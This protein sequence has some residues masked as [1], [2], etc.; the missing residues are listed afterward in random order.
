MQDLQ[1]NLTSEFQNIINARPQG[2]VLALCLHPALDVTIRTDHGREISR[3]ENLGGKAVNVA[4]MLHLLGA[5]V[6]LLA[7]D[8]CAGETSALLEN[9]GFDCEL[10]PTNLSLRRNYKYIDADGKTCEQNGS[11][12]TLSP[13]HS[14]QLIDRVLHICRTRQISHLALCGSFPQGVEKGVYKYLTEQA[15]ALNISCVTDASGES[16]SLAVQ[17]KPR[18]IKPNFDEFCAL[19][20]QDFSL[21][22]TLPD[23]QNAIKEVFSANDVPILC[24]L[25]KKGAIYAG[26]EGTYAVSGRTV[27][28]VAS[29]A[30]AGDTMLASFVYAH[31]LCSLPVEQ[32]L[33]FA[34]AAATAKVTLPAN[35]L[36]C[37]EQ[38]YAEWIQTT[39]TKK[40]GA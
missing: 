21:L 15:N 19:S 26:P 29:F 10:I 16:L 20:A 6:T 17:A 18:L 12:G 27:D 28:H 39:I 37:A 35:S 24:S 22:K 11:A 30:G 1:K 40:G 31:D 36:P 23:V 13:Q 33:R 25:D 9:C 32:S 38:I 14:Q 2:H 34:C 8:D 5:R 7:P 3:R 4:R